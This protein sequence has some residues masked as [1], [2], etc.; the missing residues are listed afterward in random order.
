LREEFGAQA[1]KR[2]DHAVSGYLGEWN[3]IPSDSRQ[4]PK[5]FYFPDLPNG[6][7]HDPFKQTWARRLQDGFQKIRDDVLRV[8]SED[9]KF[10][11]FLDL[12]GDARMTD[13]VGG[14]GDA[15]A[16]EAFFFYRHGKRY[17]ENH[18]RCPNTGAILESLDL[19]RIAD[20]SPEIC[21]SIL[22]PGSHILPHYGVTNTR[23]VMHL[24]LVV[25]QD[26]A[27]NIIGTNGEHHWKEGE[28]MM[29]DDTFQH[30]AW[31]R[32][33][34]TRIIL[35]MDCWNPCLTEIERNAVSRLVE[36]ISAYELSSQSNE[37]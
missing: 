18:K 17:D 28:L 35:L 36:T 30:E 2:V 10:Q 26:C 37:V 31:N 24:P 22:K 32:S 6:P 7:Y 21:F 19:C 11:N 27:L 13:H 4:R 25:P 5:F 1:L 20:Q 15:P 8:W 29:F 14:N 16:W 3:A 12:T 23:L 34:N 33:T 9:Q